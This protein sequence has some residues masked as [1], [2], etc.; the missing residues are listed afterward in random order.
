[1]RSPANM[2]GSE[3][4]NSLFQKICARV[5]LK[6]RASLTRSGSM[7][8]TIICRAPME[9]MGIYV[10]SAAPW[11]LIPTRAPPEASH[12]CSA[13]LVTKR[14]HIFSSFKSAVTALAVSLSRPRLDISSSI[15][16][17][18]HSNTSLG[19]ELIER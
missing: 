6:A 17:I 12:G 3:P 19:F 1:M 5:A 10:T 2:G 4:G 13:D 8:H 11:N 7:P 16:R 9:Y 15:A 14:G 18:S